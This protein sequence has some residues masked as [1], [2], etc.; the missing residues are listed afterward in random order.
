M[1]FDA[2]HG[3]MLRFRRTSRKT[4][5]RAGSFDSPDRALDEPHSYLETWDEPIE[6]ESGLVVPRYH[7]YY[8]DLEGKKIVWR[9]E[10]MVDSIVVRPGDR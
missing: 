9:T 4:I 6:L 5:T 2:E 10:L 8:S 7:N 3:N 1:D